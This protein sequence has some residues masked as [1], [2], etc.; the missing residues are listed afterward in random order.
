MIQRSFDESSSSNS[1]SSSSPCA[2]HSA[3]INN[4]GTR[5]KLN[6]NYLLV[7]IIIIFFVL[8]NCL[9]SVVLDSVGNE[10]ILDEAAEVVLHLSVSDGSHCCVKPDP[11]LSCLSS[12]Y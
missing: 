8:F 9:A 5:F 7:V 10:F 4:T 11:A 6:L 2:S 1:P 12:E 3:H